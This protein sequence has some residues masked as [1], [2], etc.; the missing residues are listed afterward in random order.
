MR[1]DYSQ[2]RSGRTT[3]WVTTPPRG[4]LDVEGDRDAIDSTTRA[5]RARRRGFAAL[6]AAC[7]TTPGARRQPAPAA[8]TAPAAPGCAPAKP[9]ETAKPAADAKPAG[10]TAT[11][12]VE[13]KAS[14]NVSGGRSS[15]YRLDDRPDAPSFYR[16]DNLIAA[17]DGLNAA[18]QKEGAPQRVQVEATFESGGTWDASSRSSPWR[19]RRS[20]D[21]HHPLRPRGP[22]GLVDGRL[23]GGARRLAQE[24]RAAVRR[25]LSV[26]LAGDEVQGQDLAVPQD[27]EARPM[28]YR[29]DLLAKLGW[30]K[31]KIDGLP[32]RSRRASGWGRPCRDGQGGDLEGRRR[33]RQGLV[34]SLVA[35]PRP[36]HL[37]H[38]N[39]GQM[40]DPESGKPCW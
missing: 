16:R 28:Y 23:R 37:H 31:E 6:A 22:G 19:L 14:G 12:V 1:P 34:P 13:A 30:P 10:S 3:A 33:E 15:S 4:R 35:R 24:V 27:T 2:R 7:S 25:R 32:T 11:P 20:R 5:A 39:G 8:T 38:Q 17:A 26:A 18:L 40:Q 9:A 36:L 29:K 21:G